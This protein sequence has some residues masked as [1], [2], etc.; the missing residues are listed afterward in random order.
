MG[1]RRRLMM[2][3]R[4]GGG[5]LLPI[6]D[7][8]IAW[9]DGKD[10]TVGATNWEASTEVSCLYAGFKLRFASGNTLVA[11][12]CM[13]V[14]NNGGASMQTA[15]NTRICNNP[16]AQVGMSSTSSM[17]IEYVFD[18]GSFSSAKR[19][20]GGAYYGNAGTYGP[21]RYIIEKSSTNTIVINYHNG[22][23]WKAFT[24]QQPLSA[25]P[26]VFSY[27]K[28][29][30][31]VRIYIDGALDLEVQNSELKLPVGA[32]SNL[33]GI[34]RYDGIQTTTSNNATGDYY[35]YAIYNRAL[36]AAEI[37]QNKQAYF[38]R[39]NLS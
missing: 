16:F 17:T 33:V 34:G 37:L 31:T 12:T 2:A 22:S 21:W 27:Q 10:I 6:A 15:S 32:Q 35:S 38:N 36:S 39:Y 28:D 24:T 18:V 3:Q 30:T 23:T 29:G 9:L 13:R 4:Q 25:G 19:I 5:N 8:L 1:F 20:G 26:H 11:G 14:G 7:G